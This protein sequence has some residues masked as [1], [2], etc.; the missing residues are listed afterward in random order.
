LRVQPLALHYKASF[1][2][3]VLQGQ[4]QK[5]SNAERNKN[6]KAFGSAEGVGAVSTFLKKNQGFRGTV[7]A[8]FRIEGFPE[9]RAASAP[10]ITQHQT[11]QRT[12]RNHRE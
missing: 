12:E 9:L 5:L 8:D 6:L 10:R 11:G 7:S 3:D 4:H 2:W 1:T